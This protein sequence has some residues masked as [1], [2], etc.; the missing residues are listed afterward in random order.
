[1]KRSLFGLLAFVVLAFAGVAF[2]SSAS[3]GGGASG[4]PMAT[5]SVS[6]QMPQ[7]VDVSPISLKHASRT[8]AAIAGDTLHTTA[9]TECRRCK[10]AVLTDFTDHGAHP[11]A[12]K[13]G[14][15][16]KGGGGK[17]PP[18]KVVLT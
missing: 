3:P 9:Q 8:S 13:G 15:A 5:Q 14:G 4:Y 18:K 11:M 16:K 6:A 10:T 1:M 17:K 7:A 12:G 2:A